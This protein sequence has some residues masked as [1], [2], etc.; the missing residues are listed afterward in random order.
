MED[1][2]QIQGDGSWPWRCH[3]VGMTQRELVPGPARF[4]FG[5]CRCRPQGVGLGQLLQHRCFCRKCFY[6]FFSWNPPSATRCFTYILVFQKSRI[7][8]TWK[9]PIASI[10]C[11]AIVTIYTPAVSENVLTLQKHRYLL[12][13]PTDKTNM[14]VILKIII[15]NKK[16]PHNYIDV[17]KHCLY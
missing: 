11:A 15:I 14:K 10:L 8:G 6:I 3:L 13:L 12:H 7:L 16:N 17:R 4:P 9:S 1:L 5:F 2:L